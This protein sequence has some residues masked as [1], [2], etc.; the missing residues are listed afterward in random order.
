MANDYFWY[1]DAIVYAID[2]GAF[3]DSNGDG[4]GDFRGAI[5]KLD[6]L[7]DLGVNCV[8]LLP[9]YKSSEKDNGYDVD[10]YYSIN[11]RFGDFDDFMIFK[12]EAESR[13][14]RLIIDLIVHHTSDNHP[15]FKL[16]CHNKHSKYYNYYVW[17]SNPPAM[18]E[19][20]VFQG[21]TWKY[22]SMNDEFYF[23]KFYEF[24]PDLNIKNPEVQ[25]EIREIIR[26][27]L[28][29][30]VSGF[31][32]DAATHLFKP[33]NEKAGEMMEEFKKFLCSLKKDA[34]FLAEADVPPG[35]IEEF[36]GDGNRMSLLYNFLLNNSIFLAL[37]RQSARP[38]IERLKTFPKFPQNVHWANFIRNLDELDLEQ[39]TPEERDEVFQAFAPTEI[40]Q[41]YGRGIRRRVAPMLEGN[42]K[43]LKMTF[44]LLFAL[45]GIPVI[46]YGDEIGMGDN[47]VYPGRTAVRT[48][49]QWDKSK[50]GGFSDSDHIEVRPVNEGVFSYHFVN[51]ED[52]KSDPSSLLNEIKRF[53]DVRHSLSKMD[54]EAFRII[55]LQEDKAAG[56]S[57]HDDLITFIN[58]SGEPVKIQT[59]YDLSEY[60]ALLEDSSYGL[61]DEDSQINLKSYGY[62]W[63]KKKG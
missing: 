18:P 33:F 46:I 37:A 23:H 8:W 15:W 21:K 62:R 6:Y 52:Q 34:F 49:M 51:V 27:W 1:N 63:F 24:E 47:L 45:P 43:R 38:V 16:A 36:V 25:K 22:C 57:Y 35:E 41:A 48:P 4:I 55:D 19:E 7:A 40:M 3:M 58:F 12:R 2:I 56:F 30:G 44:N 60:S 11:D 26:Y 32:L 5:E 61:K 14:I 20:N 50:N 31:R 10:D 59:E 9:F 29:F 53:I 17:N 54:R 39:L 42:V 28:D 13:N